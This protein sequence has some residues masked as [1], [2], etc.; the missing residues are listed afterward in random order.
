MGSFSCQEIYSHF[1]QSFAFL[2]N[3]FLCW[4]RWNGDAMPTLDAAL[5]SSSRVGSDLGYESGLVSGALSIGFPHSQVEF[6][7]YLLY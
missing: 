2:L 3:C 1:F 5:L 4:Y 7:A 6:N